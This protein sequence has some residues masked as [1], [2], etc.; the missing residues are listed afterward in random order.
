[1]LLGRTFSPGEPAGLS[2]LAALAFFL[3]ALAGAAAALFEPQTA[4]WAGVAL[5]T[6][7]GA[8]AAFLL[9]AAWPRATA[10]LEEARRGGGLLQ[11]RLG[12]HGQGRLR[13]RLQCGLSF[14]GRR[15]G[16]RAAHAA[17]ACLPGRRSCRRALSAVACCQ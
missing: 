2:R 3:L 1:A 7:V 6:V 15:R 17:A 11:C 9:I 12:G 5:L 13:A 8:A 16:G 10:G 4:R 14:A